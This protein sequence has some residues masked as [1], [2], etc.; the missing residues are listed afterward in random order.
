VLNRYKYLKF[1][2]LLKDLDEKIKLAD[3]ENKMEE[4]YSSLQKKIKLIGVRNELA[5]E[6]GTVTHPY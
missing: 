6:I 3:T 4:L 5:K 1:M 2:E